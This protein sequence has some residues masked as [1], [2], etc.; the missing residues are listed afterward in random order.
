MKRNA[1]TWNIDGTSFDTGMTHIVQQL[2]VL[3]KKER[4]ANT[5][6]RAD[7]GQASSQQH[8]RRMDIRLASARAV[9]FTG[10]RQS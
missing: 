2:W 3:M 7:A 10:W 1:F 6:T 5:T 4:P 8:K 9:A